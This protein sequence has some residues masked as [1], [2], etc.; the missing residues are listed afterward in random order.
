M[1]IK[2]SLSSK[3]PNVDLG[4]LI[5]MKLSLIVAP[6]SGNDLGDILVIVS[7]YLGK[8]MVSPLCIFFLMFFKAFSLVSVIAFDD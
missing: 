3:A 4:I 2:V 6:S 5:L 7:C 1:L 8:F